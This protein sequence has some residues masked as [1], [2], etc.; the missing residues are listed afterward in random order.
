MS[1]GK[2]LALGLLS[3]MLGLTIISFSRAGIPAF[4]P[5]QNI[6]RIGLWEREYTGGRYTVIKD[7][8]G[9]IIDMMARVVY[10]GDE[11][12]AADNTRYRVERVEGDTAYAREIGRERIAW[13]D[14]ESV[15]AAA[16]AQRA[17]AG[18]TPGGARNL[19]AIYHTHS[20]ESYVPTDGTDSIPGHGGIFKVGSVMAQKLRSQGVNVDHDLRSHDP[21]DSDAYR[22]SRRTAVSLL[23]KGPGALIDVHRDGVPDPSFYQETVANEDVTK[24]R[25]VVGREN[26]NMGAN[27]DFAKRLKAYADKKYPGLM[28]G[29]FL[30]AG[31]YNQDLSPRAILIEVGT[32]T[33]KR[34]EAQ[35]GAAL[36]ADIIPTVL[37][38]TAVPPPG[39][40]PPST[41][42]DWKGVLWVLAAFLIGGG[43]F[44]ILSAGSWEKAKARL[45]QITSI[46]WTNF[47]GRRLRKPS[48][49]APGQANVS[50]DD[51]VEEKELNDER[52]PFQKD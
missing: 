49:E 12:I 50:K 17:Q 37:G 22:R 23:Q 48:R 3:V 27:L 7:E 34:D 32:H 13:E 14:Y 2:K 5:L 1:K 45:K 43:A 21:H 10:K 33:N 18:R 4:N 38:I 26:Q 47:L 46:E 52:A 24:I 6:A 9:R 42:G 40:V 15:P 16:G 19:I 41:A 28:R 31:S 51:K 36:F 35:R 30:G 20:D 25:L 11:I 39:A 29:I 8:H 44:L